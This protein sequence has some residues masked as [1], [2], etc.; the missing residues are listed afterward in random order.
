MLHLKHDTRVSRKQGSQKLSW[1]PR[2]AVSVN[3]MRHCPRH[4]QCLQRRRRQ[5]RIRSSAMTTPACSGGP[6]E[7]SLQLN[8]RLRAL[9]TIAIRVIPCRLHRFSRN[10]SADYNPSKSSPPISQRYVSN[11]PKV[12]ENLPTYLCGKCVTVSTVFCRLT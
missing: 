8:C 10:R 7:A 2:I 3:R 11:Q 6:L 4:C 5:R 1:N 9:P 12:C